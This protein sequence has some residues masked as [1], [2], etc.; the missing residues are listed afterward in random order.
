M[1]ERSSQGVQNFRKLIHKIKYLNEAKLDKKSNEESE[2]DEV[3]GCQLDET[4][5]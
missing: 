3:M 1:M 4:K 5:Q 2:Q